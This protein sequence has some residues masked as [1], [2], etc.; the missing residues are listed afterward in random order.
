MNAVELIREACDIVGIS[1]PTSIA[2]ATD[3][4][5]RQLVGLLN[6]EGRDLSARFGWEALIAEATFA[7]QAQEDQGAISD[8]IGAAN[9]YRYILNDTMWNRSRNE[10]VCGP[11]SSVDWQALKTLGLS[12]PYT[13]Y[14]IRGGRLLFDSIPAAGENVYFEYASR[15]WIVNGVSYKRAVSD[16]TDEFRL[17]DEI[18]L[19]GVEW[20]WRRVKGLAYAEDFNSYE[21]MVADAMARDGTK[22]KLSLAKSV[23]SNER[24]WAVSPGSWPL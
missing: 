14:R 5:V 11:Q 2:S 8:I 23:P 16:D 15:N 13:T 10:P 24:R 22:R 7:T 19:R 4:G 1:R 18:L 21:R 6:D 20:R 9:A 17:D 12:G 3:K